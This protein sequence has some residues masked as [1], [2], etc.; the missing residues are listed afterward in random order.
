M[1]LSCCSTLKQLYVDVPCWLSLEL[2]SEDLLLLVYTKADQIVWFYGH[3]SAIDG[4]ES[5][6]SQHVA[7][8][9]VAG[10][11]KQLG[12]TWFKLRPSSLINVIIN[13]D[14]QGSCLCQKKN[15]DIFKYHTRFQ[16]MYCTVSVILW[17]LV[18]KPVRKTYFYNTTT[19]FTHRRL[20]AK[21]SYLTLVRVADRIL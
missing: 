4:I 9:L 8:K 7:H 17:Y 21:G 2:D 13:I 12:H 6:S 14:K 19:W 10:C 3:K 1:A 20:G 18:I 5:L 16:M 15:Y 11:G